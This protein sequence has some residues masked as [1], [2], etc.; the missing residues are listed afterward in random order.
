MWPLI[1]KLLKRN[2]IKQKINRNTKINDTGKIKVG[3]WTIKNYDYAK[4]PNPGWIDL[5]YLFEH[6]SNIA[7]IKIAQMM[8]DKEFYDSLKLFN[9]GD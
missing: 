7:S 1:V 2:R 5:V 3:W 4:H 8:S 6:S 9:F